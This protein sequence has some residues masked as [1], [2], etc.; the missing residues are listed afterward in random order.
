MYS[1]GKGVDQDNEIALKWFEKS[2]KQGH[3]DSLNIINS[4]Y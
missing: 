4:M 1:R 2:A 3:T